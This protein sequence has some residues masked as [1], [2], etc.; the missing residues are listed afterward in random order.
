MMKR[1]A[2]IEDVVKY[3]QDRFKKYE[4]EEADQQQFIDIMIESNQF[5]SKVDA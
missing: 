1:D 5:T 3:M 4:N 2:P